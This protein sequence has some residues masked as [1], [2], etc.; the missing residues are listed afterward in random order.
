[1][2]ESDLDREKEGAAAAEPA[3]RAGGGRGRR[4]LG[5]LESPPERGPAAY[6]AEFIGTFGLVFIICAVVT[7]YAHPPVPASQP[8]VPATQPFQDWA[9]IGVTIAFVVFGLIQALAIVS[10]AHFNPAV[11][12]ALAAIRQIRLID[13]AIYIVVQLIGALAGA[14]VV[15][16]LFD[17]PNASGTDNPTFGAV[18]VGP[19]ADGS[20]AV[21]L[22]AEVIGTFFLVWAIVGVA[23]NPRGTKDWAGFAIG[24]TLGAVIMLFGSVSG[25]GVNPARSFGPAVVGQFGESAGTWI[26]IWVIGPLVGALLAAFVYF[27]MFILPGR[28]GAEGMEP[29][30]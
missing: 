4:L 7:L 22:G 21:A 10:G 19:A 18:A 12:V 25:A 20:N 11:T 1:M 13:A 27:Q 24:A 17:N 9:V 8:G 30:G 16:L 29:V 6:V 15:K 2:A 14:F 26:L 28:K 23:V 5:E 3:P